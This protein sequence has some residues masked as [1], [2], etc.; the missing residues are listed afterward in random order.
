M[1]DSA[2]ITRLIVRSDLLLVS[3]YSDNKISANP[4]KWCFVL[5][6]SPA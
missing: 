1:N 2:D 3:T 5:R 6:Q 4:S